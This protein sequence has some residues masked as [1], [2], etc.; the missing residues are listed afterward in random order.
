MAFHT[1]ECI[2]QDGRNWI[3]HY[4]HSELDGEQLW[5]STFQML[6][7]YLKSNPDEVSEELESLHIVLIMIEK[8]RLKLQMEEFGTTSHYLHSL[9]VLR[10]YFK[11]SASYPSTDIIKG[12]IQNRINAFHNKGILETWAE[13]YVMD[14]LS[15][16]EPV[17][18]SGY[19]VIEAVYG[20]KDSEVWQCFQDEAK[21]LDEEVGPIKFWQKM[22]DKHGH[23]SSLENTIRSASPNQPRIII[24]IE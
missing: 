6:D 15:I 18:I 8:T 24:L 5:G 23:L 19:V 20:G 12:D 11:N 17:D 10:H 22:F 16:T 9:F 3:E 4:H 7:F 21:A 2:I 13:A 1:K 14:P